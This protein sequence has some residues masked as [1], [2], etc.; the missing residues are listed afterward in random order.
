[1]PTLYG[2]HVCAHVCVYESKSGNNS[3][4]FPWLRRPFWWRIY[5]LLFVYLCIFQFST[6]KQ[7]V[8]WVSF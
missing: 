1:M 2:A 8:I 6:M 7:N 5:F 4:T 3:P